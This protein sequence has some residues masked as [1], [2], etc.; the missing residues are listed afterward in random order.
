[1]YLVSTHRLSSQGIPAEIIVVDDSDHDH[2]AAVLSQV[3]ERMMDQLF[4]ITAPDYRRPDGR[5]RRATP[6]RIPPRNRGR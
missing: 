2:T 1:V 3:R 6:P 5:V 4:E